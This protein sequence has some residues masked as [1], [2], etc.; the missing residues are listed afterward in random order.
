MIRAGTT[1]ALV[2]ALSLTAPP[3]V[4]GESERIPA[5]YG[6]G[7]EHEVR[8]RRVLAELPAQKAK[9][10]RAERRDGEAATEACDPAEVE[11]LGRLVPTSKRAD[12]LPRGCVVVPKSD[13]KKAE[14]L[15][16]APAEFTGS[17][18]GNTAL[19]GARRPQVAVYLSTRGNAK[20]AFVGPQLANQELAVT[21]NGQLLE[22]VTFEPQSSPT[23]SASFILG[24]EHGFTRARA[25]EIESQILDSKKE[26]V[27]ELVRLASL[28]RSARERFALTDPVIRE[29][30]DFADDCPLPEADDTFVLGCYD[31]FED[32]LF[33][34]RV[35]RLDLLGVMP[36]TAAHELLHAAYSDLSRVERRKV[37]RM[38]EDFLD[39]NPIAR[40]EEDIALYE[41]VERAD[42]LHALVGTEVRDLPAPL[43]RYYS[44]Y[45]DDRSETVRLFEA[46]EGTFNGL[47]TRIGQIEAELQRIDARL[48]DLDGQINAASAEAQRLGNEIL[49]LRAQG[50]IGESNNLVGPQNAAVD[51][52]DAL[53]NEYNALVNQY[54]ANVEE[55]NRLIAGLGELYN[56]ITVQ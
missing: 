46:Y 16:L 42:E 8:I 19:R 23:D 41:E 22:L 33:I 15:L 43:E 2:L 14:R 36:V 13:R 10:R 39:E 26:E 31:E 35:E 12:D 3:A 28:S 20:W 17:E 55:A 9:L 54:N 49:A 7:R 18:L 21:L 30:A 5:G 48:T 1:T 47:E 44:Q 38:I 45:F 25:E 50:R 32:K 24:G 4:A 52:V 27:I 53:I 40:I 11:A 51:R 6:E 56:Q 37:D 34:L 29:H